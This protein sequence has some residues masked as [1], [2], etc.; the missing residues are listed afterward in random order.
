MPIKNSNVVAIDDPTDVR[1]DD[2]RDLARSDR[3]PD[4]PGGKGLVIAEG[5]SV[6]ERMIQSPYPMRSIMGVAERVE[7]ALANA[8]VSS[9]VPVYVVEPTVMN[10][11]IGFHLNRGVLAIA[12][13]ACRS[14][15]NW[16]RHHGHCWC[17]RA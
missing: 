3:R 1:L 8:P 7:A 5:V 13:R 2:Y 10:T 4:R 11:A 16:S 6:V 12:D 17:W 14:L 9:E 15:P